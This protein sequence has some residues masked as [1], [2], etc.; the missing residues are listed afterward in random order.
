MLIKELEFIFSRNGYP[1]TLE[2]DNGLNLVSVEMENYLYCKGIHHAKLTTYLPRISREAELYNQ[3]L[4][5][6]IHVVH[7]EAKV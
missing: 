5:K 7:L 4:L 2:I 6:S 1:L 3:T